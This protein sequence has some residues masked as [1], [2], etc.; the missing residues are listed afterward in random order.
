MLC[1]SGGVGI[2]MSRKADVSD[3]PFVKR[4]GR[5]SVVMAT[6]NGGR[7]LA[8]QLETLELQTCAPLELIIFDDGST[9]D[10]LDIVEQFRTRASFPVLIRRNADRL[11]YGGNFLSAVKL[12]SGEFIAFCDQDDVWLPQKLETAMDVLEH[13]QADLFVHAAELIDDV[14]R[15]IG[16][17]SQGIKRSRMYLPLALP[18]WGV[19]YGCTMVFSRKMIDLIDS[20]HRGAHTFEH[21]GL[22]S[23]DL[24]IYFLGQS[25]YRVAVDKRAL[26][27]YRQ[28]A[29]NQTP[30]IR[31]S[32]LQD[33]KTSLGVAAHPDLR[34][35][36]IA[37]HRSNL[38]VRVAGSGS[39]AQARSA[40]AKGAALWRS[41]GKR[42][43]SRINLYARMSFLHRLTGFIGLWMSGGYL[44]FRNGGLGW[45]LSLKDLLVGVFRVQR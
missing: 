12:A 19:F 10:T 17:F 6:F 36:L 32:W 31:R 11:G 20:D 33:F 2:S 24:W 5:V 9:D 28:H 13:E 43:A 37:N 8:E 29:H 44:P 41:I 26:V 30:H 27:K 35:D 21:E 22:L 4:G 15:P 7:F 45:R 42:E 40:A 38:L 14:G 18:P 23:H 3:P 1:L 34:R 25:M 16:L 39:A